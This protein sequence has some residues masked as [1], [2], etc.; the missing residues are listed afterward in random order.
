MPRTPPA[1]LHPD[2]AA[3]APG[4]AAAAPLPAEPPPAPQAQAQPHAPAARP[5]TPL[6]P[7]PQPLCY[8]TSLDMSHNRLFGLPGGLAAGALGRSLRCLRLRDSLSGLDGTGAARAMALLAGVRDLRE[9]R[10]GERGGLEHRVCAMAGGCVYH[11]QQ[12]KVGSA[13]CRLAA[14]GGV[15]WWAAARRTRCGLTHPLLCAP[16]RP[17]TPRPSPRAAGPVLQPPGPALHSAA[18]GAAQPAA[19]VAVGQRTGG[20]RVGAR[21]GAGP[22]AGGVGGPAWR[23]RVTRH[24]RGRHP[25]CDRCSSVRQIHML[26]GPRRPGCLGPAEL[27]NQTPRHHPWAP[28]CFAGAPPGPGA[29]Q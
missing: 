28:L 5:A 16:P 22:V 3:A 8:M 6:S 19:A 13:T 24:T 2:A 23:P 14:A 27:P 21:A 7:P 4:G 18:V 25:M 9:V 15:A 1:G 20:E 29:P 26:Q 11:V 10:A 17:A 12:C